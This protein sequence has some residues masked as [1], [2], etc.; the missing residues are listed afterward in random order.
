MELADL[1]RFTD[2]LS[3]VDLASFDV[4]ELVLG[5]ERLRN[6]VASRSGEAL[7]VLHE[8]GAFAVGGATCVAH[9]LAI[10]AG[11]PSNETRARL[12]TALLL[13]Q[14]PAALAASAAG[15]LHARH[16]QQL[17]ACVRDFPALAQEADETLTELARTLA[18][19]DFD[20]AI[21]VWRELA[22]DTREAEA[23]EQERNAAAAEPNQV[24]LHQGF[25][26]RWTL[27]A[28]LQPD[29]GAMLDGLLQEGFERLSRARRDGDPA[30]ERH[31]ASMLRGEALA[32]LVANALRHEPGEDSA[33][34][35]YRAAVILT[36]DDLTEPSLAC[37]DSPLFRLVVGAKGDV[38]GVGR[39]SR[40]W[41]RAAR[42]GMVHRDGGCV[43]PGCDRPPSWCDVHHC[44][45]WRDGGRT[46][47][48]N[49]A[50]LCRRHHTFL[51][52]RNWYI[53]FI[54]DK[55]VVHTDED[56][57]FEPIRWQLE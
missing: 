57:P 27:T 47:F 32:D 52:H 34:D 12:R 7:V 6:V 49:G 39:I 51:H 44:K 54:D 22:A 16:Q 40:I 33:P 31:D 50:L 55:P 28:N 4:V 18:P 24:W 21:K 53:T 38:L 8:T 25:A 10:R 23:D 15:E 35:R 41:R 29:I 26:G 13:R 5:L 36:P 46:D 56:I 43:F 2:D 30:L 42:R 45:H 20:T 37:C 19:K 17:A 14:L 9:F 3:I 1:H 48:R 11:A